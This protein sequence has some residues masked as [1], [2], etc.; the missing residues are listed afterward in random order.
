MAGQSRNGKVYK[1]V[2]VKGTRRP[3]WA[4]SG[5]RVVTQ[6]SRVEKLI[7]WPVAPSNDMEEEDQLSPH[8]KPPPPPSARAQGR[9]LSPLHLPSLPTRGRQV[10]SMINSPSPGWL[11]E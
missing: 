10:I 4:L 9:A 6:W 11:M 5:R 1:C 3:T 7:G 2:G 8:A